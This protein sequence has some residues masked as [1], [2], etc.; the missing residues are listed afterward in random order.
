M[1]K[2]DDTVKKRKRMVDMVNAILGVA[3]EEIILVWRENNGK[4][5]ELLRRGGSFAS[6]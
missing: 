5:R 2:A 6:L 3:K 4:G 1:S